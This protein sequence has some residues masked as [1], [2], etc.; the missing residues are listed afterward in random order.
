MHINECVYIH[1]Y[2]Y[3][4]LYV[5]M[6]VFVCDFNYDITVPRRSLFIYTHT[7]TTFENIYLSFRN[8]KIHKNKEAYLALTTLE[9]LL[10]KQKVNYLI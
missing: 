9:L 10:I 3:I 2:A 5:R 7:H 1:T 4:Y 6:C 8:F